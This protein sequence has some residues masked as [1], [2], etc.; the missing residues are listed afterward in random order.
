MT[1]TE[2]DVSGIDAD[3]FFDQIQPLVRDQGGKSLLL[4]LSNILFVRETG[5]QL[6]L[7]QRFLEMAK[8]GKEEV[9]KLLPLKHANA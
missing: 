6:R 7:I 5:E 1:Q 9:L 8:T 4:P 2:F 3:S